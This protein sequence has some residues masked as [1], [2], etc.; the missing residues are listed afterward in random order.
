MTGAL[1]GDWRDLKTLFE[2]TGIYPAKDT[3]LTEDS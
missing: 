1:K 3:A 2:F